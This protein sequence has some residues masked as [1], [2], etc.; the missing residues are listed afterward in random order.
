MKLGDLVKW[1][2]FPGATIPI[3]EKYGIVIKK[4]RDPVLHPA[5]NKRVDVLW[6][7]GTI[8]NKY[9][10]QLLITQNKNIIVTDCPIKWSNLH[11]GC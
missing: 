1:I 11:L 6:A 10:Y 7:D 8:G 2:G 3:E 4:T 9:Q 5:S